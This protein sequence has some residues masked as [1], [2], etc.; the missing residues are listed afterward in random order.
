VKNSAKVTLLSLNTIAVFLHDAMVS[1]NDV[2][3]EWQCSWCVCVG[4]F[5]LRLSV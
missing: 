4:N 2:L 5:E 1:E 3:H